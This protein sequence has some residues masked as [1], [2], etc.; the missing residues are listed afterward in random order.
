MYRIYY[1]IPYQR[2]EHIAKTLDDAMNI[3]RVHLANGFPCIVEPM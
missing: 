3:V 2:F 1:Y